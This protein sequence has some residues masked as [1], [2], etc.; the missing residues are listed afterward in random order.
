VINFAKFGG[1]MNRRGFV[2]AM[3]LMG[4]GWYVVG[5]IILGAGGGQWLDR[6]LDTLPLFTLIGVILGTVLAFY[7]LIK[8][9]RPLMGEKDGFGKE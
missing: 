2:L 1:G 3:R 7:G 9:V 5:S 6:R 4:L 8:M